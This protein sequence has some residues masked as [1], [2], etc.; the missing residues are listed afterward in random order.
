VDG[1]VLSSRAEWVDG[2]IWR[3]LSPRRYEPLK[4]FSGDLSQV[5]ER[6]DEMSSFAP[7]PRRVRCCCIISNNTKHAESVLQ[8]SVELAVKT[9]SE[10]PVQCLIM[11][12]LIYEGRR[13]ANA[14]SGARAH[15]M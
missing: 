1:W 13:K 6:N 4:M 2:W 9:S 8:F 3:H 12:S 11:L 15:I 14:H 7:A 5:C 10:V